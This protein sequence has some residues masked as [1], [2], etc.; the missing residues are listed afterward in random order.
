[1]RVKQPKKLII[2]NILDILRKYTD[3][4]HRLSQREIEEILRTEYDMEV[5]RKAVKR[6]LMNL[7]DFGYQIEFSESIRMV[8]NPKTGELEESAVYSDFY[9]E[10]DFTDAELRLLIDSL[11]FSRHIPFGQCRDLI[12]KLKGLSNIYF[13]SR[14]KHIARMPEDRTANRQV[15]LNIELLDEAITRNR[16]VSFKYLDYGTDKVQRPKKHADGTEEY[17]VSPYQMAAKEGKYYLICNY[18]KY[19]D[20]SNYRIDRICDLRI[21]DDQAKPFETLEWSGGRPLDLEDYMKK[22]VYM[23]SGGDRRVKFRIVRAMVSDVIDL[24]G[25]DVTFSEETGSTVCVTVYTN[26]PSAV[27]FAKSYAPDVILL[28]PMELAEEV[29]SSLERAMVVYKERG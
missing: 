6:N 15:F 23:Y 1:M 12:C 9:L 19:Q 11:L 25:K 26:A 5:D 14:V 16:K 8:P 2:F 7:L 4:D 18:D 21:L 3:A 17:I 29:K 13:H 27:Q 20:I 10:R 28:E 22:H 24:F